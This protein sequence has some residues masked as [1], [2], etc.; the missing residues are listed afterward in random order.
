MAKKYKK[1]YE[2]LFLT[3]ELK[4]VCTNVWACGIDDDIKWRDFR[5]QNQIFGHTRNI[6]INIKQLTCFFDHWD[7]FHLDTRLLTYVMQNR[8]QNS[9]FFFF[10]ARFDRISIS[11][12]REHTEDRFLQNSASQVLGS[13]LNPVI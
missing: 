2:F 8:F 9:T 7:I 11:P 12:Y 5:S 3:N 4:I 6:T 10:L 13:E 1:K